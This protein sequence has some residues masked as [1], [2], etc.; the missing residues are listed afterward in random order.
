MHF[1]EIFWVWATKLVLMCAFWWSVVQPRLSAFPFNGLYGDEW[2]MELLHYSVLQLS[3]GGSRWRSEVVDV[4]LD[5]EK[6]LFLRLFPSTSSDSNC[7]SHY[8]PSSSVIKQVV[9]SIPWDIPGNYWRSRG[10]RKVHI[11]GLFTKLCSFSPGQK[12]LS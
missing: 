3:D 8:L 12:W 7:S 6:L 1:L 5:A 11:R 2:E 10:R 4:Q 9:P